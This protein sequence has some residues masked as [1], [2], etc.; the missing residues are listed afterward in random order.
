MTENTA[1]MRL[2]RVTTIVMG[3]VVSDESFDL[4]IFRASPHD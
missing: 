1:I 3:N 4:F 2:P